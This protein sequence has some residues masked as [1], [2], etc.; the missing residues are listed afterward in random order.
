MNFAVFASGNGGNLQAII[1][2]VKK[3]KIKAKLTV[4]FSDKKDAFALERARKAGIPVVFLSPKEFPTPEAFDLA[5]LAEL[6]I[7]TVDFIVL[8]G[9][10]R[11]L[12]KHF[13]QQYPHKI[14]NIHPSLLPAFKGAHGIKDAFEFGVKVTGVSVHFIDENMDEGTIMMQHAVEITPK[15]TLESLAK[16]IH[17]V[18]HAIYP[19][20]I[21]LFA[22][23]K[24]KHP[25]RPGSSPSRP[26][27]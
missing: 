4:V 26:Q 11:L 1:D 21:D 16:K 10:M 18:E 17:A 22:K 8:A 7:Y 12:S 14:L 24:L 13:I 15:D 27:K 19:T 9:Y 25:P 3:K 20:A 2:A 23:G 5:V 6:Q